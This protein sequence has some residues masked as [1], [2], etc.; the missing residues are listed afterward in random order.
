MI[1]FV[2]WRFCAFVTLGG[3]FGYTY[4]A[5]LGLNVQMYLGSSPGWHGLL[6]HALRM[7]AIIVAFALCAHI[8]A[9][10]LISSVTGFHLIRALA[11]NRQTLRPTSKS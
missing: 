4:L 1:E 10:A 11:I 8:G 5:A 7:T 2:V 9:M 6:L 3:L